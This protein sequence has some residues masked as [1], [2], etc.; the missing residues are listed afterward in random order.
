[1]RN[2]RGSIDAHA[3]YPNH[4]SFSAK[5]RAFIDAMKA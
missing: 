3:L 2:N 4:R 5:V 1:V